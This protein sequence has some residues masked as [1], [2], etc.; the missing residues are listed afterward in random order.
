[1]TDERIPHPTEVGASYAVAR[2]LVEFERDARFHQAH[3]RSNNY[4]S[5]TASVRAVGIVAAYLGVVEYR[6]TASALV[7]DVLAERPPEPGPRWVHEA[8]VD[9]A[10]RLDA[11]KVAR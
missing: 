8:A 7:S 3:P 11:R 1:M 6:S 9:L 10:A 5:A 2:A 4:R